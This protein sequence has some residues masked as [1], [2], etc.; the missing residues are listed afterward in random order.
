MGWGTMGWGAGP[1][2]PQDSE[3]LAASQYTSLTC[4]HQLPITY[5]MTTTYWRSKGVGG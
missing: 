1:Y 3:L 4:I 5:S 2:L